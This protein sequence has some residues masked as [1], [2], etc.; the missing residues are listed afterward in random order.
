M[1]CNHSHSILDLSSS[2]FSIIQI[3]LIY[4]EFWKMRITQ[5]FGSPLL[6]ILLLQVVYFRCALVHIVGNEFESHWQPFFLCGNIPYSRIG[7]L[8]AVAPQMHSSLESSSQSSDF[9][10]LS[11]N[12]LCLSPI[13]SASN[14]QQRW[15]ARYFPSSRHAISLHLCDARHKKKVV[16]ESRMMQRP[17]KRLILDT[18]THLLTHCTH[19]GVVL[20][21]ATRC[22]G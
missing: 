9:E 10:N 16:G 18:V 3:M 4:P 19:P 8:G 2:I 20:C 17:T 22:G 11:K 13:I 5:Q 1:L 7:T 21:G 14:T 6:C 12:K 15:M